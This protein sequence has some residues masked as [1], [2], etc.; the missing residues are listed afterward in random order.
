M[1]CVSQQ[2]QLNKSEKVKKKYGV[3]KAI[4]WE[5]EVLSWKQ[6]VTAQD[7]LETQEELRRE[8]FEK[9][10]IEGEIKGEISTIKALIKFKIPQEKIVT[11]VKFFTQD[12]VKE[13]LESNLIYIQNHLE[14][15]DS[16]ICDELGLVGNLLSD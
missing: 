13:Q 1:K 14:D 8:A 7:I 16:D 12:K 4:T 5:Q 9:G 11:R 10:K 15:S 6:R 3:M 2:R